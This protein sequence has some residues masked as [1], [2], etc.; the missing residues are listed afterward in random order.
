VP[1]KELRDK[2]S[3]Q[4]PGLLAELKRSAQRWVDEPEQENFDHFFTKVLDISGSAGMFG[5]IAIGNIAKSM[6]AEMSPFFRSD[7]KPNPSEMK[8]IIGIN[9][10]LLSML[11][12]PTGVQNTK[13][14]EV[15]FKANVINHE[16]LH[17]I[18]LED[19]PT[20]AEDISHKLA[21]AGFE[22]SIITDITQIKSFLKENTCCILANLD[23][24]ND[25]KITL[26][27]EIEEIR[28]SIPL[29]FL[30]KDN[31]MQAR[32]KAVQAGGQA[33]ISKPLDYT[34]LLR[35]IDSLTERHLQKKYRV[36]IVDDQKS[37]SD[38]YSNI[39][40]ASNFEVLAVNDPEHQLMPALIDFVPDLILLDLYM[41]YC[42]GQDLAGII[43]QIDNLISIPLVFLS[44]EA[45]SDLQLRAMSTGADAF[46]TKPVSPDDLLLTVQSRIK[47]GRAVHELVTK[48]PLS[49]LLNRR[50]CIRRLNE[51]ISRSR[52]NQ[53]PLTVAMLDLDHFKKINDTL[54]HG[55]GDW[56]IKFFSRSMQ[57]IFRECDI[58]GRHGGEEF[59]VIF[60]DT[61][62]ETAQLACK[63]LKKYIIAS[64]ID[65]PTS[66]TFSGGIA[67]LNINDTSTSILDRA[68]M[69]LYKAKQKGRNKVITATDNPTG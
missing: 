24:L 53:T 14:R 18:V 66:F 16:L 50:E 10:Q 41:P 33:F 13:I 69:A 36:L 31:S 43:R 39:L 15:L 22:I 68:D 28:S 52:R 9:E 25:E 35:A 44:A 51:E 19:E 17:I 30:S 48:D 8:R 6:Q 37:L 60:P 34:Q 7:N 59:V 23:N 20:L 63:R 4:I 49:G 42:N 46:L 61:E 56:V 64:E 57:M 2:Y 67:L 3:Q 21:S 29:I 47:R 65:L 40:A 27:A 32:L 1:D 5:H 26:V 55:I 54:G 38:Y 45:S 11:Q 58:I 12:L 62:S